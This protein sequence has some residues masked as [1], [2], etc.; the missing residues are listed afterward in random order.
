ME[1]KM[2]CGPR[3]PGAQEGG[4]LALEKERLHG[5]ESLRDV[6]TP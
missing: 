2:E 6:G 4:P 3:S 1:E 5:G